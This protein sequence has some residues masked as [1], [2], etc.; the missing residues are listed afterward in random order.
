[1][2]MMSPRLRKLALSAHML[3]SVG[4]MGALAAF[5]ALA[6]FGFVGRDPVAARAAYV[7]NGAITSYVIVPLAFAALA[8]GIV[9]ALATP[10][11]LF[12]HFWV[13]IKLVIVAAATFMLVMKTGPIGYIA[14]IAAE[15]ALEPGA[16]T[17]LRGSILAHAVGGFLVLAWAAALGMYKPHGLTRHGWRMRRQLGTAAP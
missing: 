16:L 5:L 10:W 3:V 2:M 1:M 6:A 4:W 14:A 8:T 11:G 17:G 7:A 15:G 12:R 9:Q 13:V